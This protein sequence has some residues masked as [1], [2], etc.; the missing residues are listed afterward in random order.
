MLG[1]SPKKFGIKMSL[2]RGWNRLTFKAEFPASLGVCL[3]C[4]LEMFLCMF[5]ARFQL[6]V[7]TVALWRGWVV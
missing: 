7:E 5:E 3:P 1:Y 2:F 6:G 4:G